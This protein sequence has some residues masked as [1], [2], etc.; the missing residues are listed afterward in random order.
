[1]AMFCRDVFW[2][3]GVVGFVS[4]N[5]RAIVDLW[6]VVWS[7]QNYDMGVVSWESED[8]DVFDNERT[9]CTIS[10]SATATKSKFMW[11]LT[12]RPSTSFDS[13]Q[14][15]DPG[16]LLLSMVPYNIH[17]NAPGQRNYNQGGNVREGA[18]IFLATQWLYDR[19]RTNEQWPSP[20][21]L[22]L[23]TVY[24]TALRTIHQ[25]PLSPFNYQ[26]T[27]LTTPA[28]KAPITGLW[29]ASITFRNSRTA[30]SAQPI[31]SLPT[32]FYHVFTLVWVR[33]G[34]GRPL[35]ETEL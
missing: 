23:F 19:H 3:L 7:S 13:Q 27:L 14:T 17:H 35:H 8:E 9:E 12:A 11:A 1:M 20:Y 21:C 24:V 26:G 32:S 15:D 34:H 10:F 2:W 30:H 6:D 22:Q 31:I 4:R 25:P 28:Q 29:L 16:R 33:I 18:P 5:Y